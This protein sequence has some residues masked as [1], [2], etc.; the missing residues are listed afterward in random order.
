MARAAAAHAPDGAVVRAQRWRGMLG[1]RLVNTTRHNEEAVVPCLNHELG[2][3]THYSEGVVPQCV[4][5]RCA[6]AMPGSGFPFGHL[7]LSATKLMFLANK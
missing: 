7:F 5:L 1:Y 2:M 3:V 6:R 4:M